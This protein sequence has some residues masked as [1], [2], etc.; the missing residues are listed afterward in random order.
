MTDI[1]VAIC[2][3][4]RAA[5]LDRTLARLAELR[6]PPGLDYEVLVVDNNSADGTPGVLARHAGKLP[7]RWVREDKQGHSH[8]RNRAVAEAKGELVVWTDDDVLVAPDWLVAIAQA[9]RDFPDAAYF[10][11][12][13]RPWFES[14][15]P[16]WVRDNLTRLGFCWALVDYGPE[17]RILNP[18][19]YPYGANMAARRE[20][21]VRFPFDPAYGR[22][23]K[24]LSSGDDT[25]VLDAIAQ[26][27]GRGVWVGDAAV[28]HFLPAE[29][30]T[31][32]YVRQIV[33]WSGY[34]AH[35]PFAADASPRLLGAPRWLWRR[36]LALGASARWK[37][38]TRRADW[39]AVLAD[40]AKAAGLLARF[41]SERAR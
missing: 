3:W 8:A 6:V 15:P 28:D 32:E 12:P 23:G 26:A 34:H 39:P 29:R 41:R 17:T 2:T 1:T 30:M 18:G 10:G 16:D 27:G 14:P 36:R 40:A 9:A 11:G 25:R 19:E 5:L 38:L 37:R 21:L 4:N 22:V 35:E 33:Y 13:V 31:P 20:W 24:Q 7:L